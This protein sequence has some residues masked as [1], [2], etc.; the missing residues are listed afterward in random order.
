[1]LAARGQR[2]DLWCVQRAGRVRPDRGDDPMTPAR[3]YVLRTAAAWATGLGL[4]AGAQS[5]PAR[6]VR[7]VS[8]YGPGGSQLASSRAWWAST[9]R[10]GWGSRSSV[11]T[12]AGARDPAGRRVRGARN[13]RRLHAAARGGP[14]CDRGVPSIRSCPTTSA[15]ASRRS[16]APRSAGVLIVNADS[17]FHGLADLSSWQGPGQRPDVRRR[18]PP[19]GPI[20][21]RNCCCARRA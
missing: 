7:I 15:R 14:V 18:V 16:A 6:A 13:P 21:R 5:W 12:S 1:V 8:P 20:W 3:R 17:P 9:S 10:A 19:R 2:S 4:P 11:D